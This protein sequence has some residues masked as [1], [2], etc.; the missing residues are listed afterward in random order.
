MKQLLQLN[1]LEEFRSETYENSRLYKEKT[2][3]WHNNQILRRE[4][5]PWQYVLLFNS[6]L[7][8]FLGKLKSRWSGPS[9]LS[10]YSHLVLLNSWEMMDGLFVSMARA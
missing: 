10:K 9:K 4:F 3:R 6:H 7:K 1:E 2:K 8:L 5:L